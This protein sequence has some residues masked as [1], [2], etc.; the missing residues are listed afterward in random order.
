MKNKITKD[1]ICRALKFMAGKKL[2]I[3]QRIKLKYFW[4]TGNT[5]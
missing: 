3:K 4:K 5:L 1:D 2:T